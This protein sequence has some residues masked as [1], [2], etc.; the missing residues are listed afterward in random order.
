MQ[1]MKPM[2]YLSR[3]F[4]VLLLPLLLSCAGEGL[5]LKTWNAYRNPLILSNVPNPDVLQENGT[6]Y[7]YSDGAADEEVISLMASTDLVDWGLLDPLFDEDTRPSFIPGGTV[8]GPSVIKAGGEYLLYYSLWKSDEECGIGVASAP[9]PTGPWVDHGALICASAPGPTGLTQPFAFEAEGALWLAFSASDGIYLL[10]LATSGRE[11]AANTSPVRI[12]E[13]PL[14]TPV[15]FQEG[16]RWY[17]LATT[18]S[19]NAGASST[20]VITI[21]SASSLKGPYAE[22]KNLID[23]STKFAGAGSPSRLI[24]DS[25][26]SDWILYNAIDLSNISSGRTLMLDRIHWDGTDVPWVRGN[27]SSFYTDAPVI[28]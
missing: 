28:Q 19:T 15:L 20:A 5:D 4:P 18:G 2:K 16:G 14:T 21:C 11:P 27:A 24:R 3:L 10:P 6:W 26:G 8:S 1:I 23:R 7:L 17:L 22:W 25:D 12:I 13:G 9:T